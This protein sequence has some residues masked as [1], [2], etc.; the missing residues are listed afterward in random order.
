MENLK[1]R[2]Q[3]GVIGDGNCSENASLLAY[4]TG[5]LIAE[6]KAVLVTGGL[7]GVMENASRGAKEAGGLVLGILPGFEMSDANRYVD[8]AIPTGM[9]H[10]RNVLVVRSSMVVIAVEGS[11]GTL[12]EIA[13]SLKIGVPVIGLNTWDVSTDIIKAATPEEAVEK[14]VLMVKDGSCR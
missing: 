2:I 6:N 3:I 1:N 5:R 11:Y 8:I 12:S 13:L 10:A 4:N 14:A 7:F 9:S